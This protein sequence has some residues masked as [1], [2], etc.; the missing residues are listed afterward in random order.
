MWVVLAISRASHHKTLKEIR[1]TED[2]LD[3]PEA[4]AEAAK[5]GVSPAIHKLDFIFH[6]HIRIQ[7]NPN[8]VETRAH[9]TDYYFKDG[10][11]S[12]T[13]L[14]EIVKQYH[15][16]SAARRL[17]LLEFASGYGAVSRHL[18][19][20]A[21]KYDLVACDIHSSAIN[22]LRNNLCTN[23]ILS[24]S[25]PED[26]KADQKFDVVFALSFFSHM[27]PKT[28][29]SWIAT[30]LAC[31]EQ[32]GLLI[33]TTHGRESYADVRSPLLSPEGYWFSPV[34]EQD[35]LPTDEYGCM[36]STPFYVAE[37][38]SK[39]PNAALICFQESFWWGKQ[40]LY[41]IKKVDAEFRPATNLSN[42]AAVD[43]AQEK[44]ALDEKLAHSTTMIHELQAALA[45][46]R[47][48]TSWRVTAPLRK[49]GAIYRKLVT[50]SGL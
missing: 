35:D 31:V 23:A 5:F 9:V 26:F 29:G 40:D 46:T 47:D 17:S 13:Q 16:H 50:K 4:V 20:M 27:P 10:S 33:F 8:S 25:R 34:S 1:L 49:V 32:D 48:S 30:L 6:H 2:L 38:I 39:C 28:F 7:P 18:S 15:C 41:I 19:K 12:A 21:E 37:Q 22:F 11:R 24:D 36:I 3:I 43:V 42:Q 45:I 14:D 44:K